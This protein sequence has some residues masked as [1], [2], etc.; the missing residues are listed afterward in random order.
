MVDIT[1]LLVQLIRLRGRL[2]VLGGCCV[3]GA[4]SW[5]VLA[6]WFSEKNSSPSMDHMFTHVFSVAILSGVAG[7]AIFTSRFIEIVISHLRELQTRKTE[8]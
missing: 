6:S 5:M 3:S 2:G 8:E 1:A 4:M 7:A